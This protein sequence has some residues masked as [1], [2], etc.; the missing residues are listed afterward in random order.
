MNPED[1]ITTAIALVAL[2][3]VLGITTLP[4]AVQ[5]AHGST[6]TDHY[7]RGYGNGCNGINVPGT[8][9][10]EYLNGYAAGAAGHQ[11]H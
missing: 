8:H 5:T 3:V 10:A 6:D 1:K 9:T 7:N 11:G 4:T 2:V